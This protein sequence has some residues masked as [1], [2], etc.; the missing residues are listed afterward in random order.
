MNLKT[1]IISVLIG[2]SAY[3]FAQDSSGEFHFPEPETT[4][5]STPLSL[6]STQYYIHEFRSGGA[7]PIVYA[8]GESSGL[9][10]DTCDFCTASLEGTAYVTDSLGTITVINFAKSGDSSFVDCRACKKYASSKLKVESWGKT[11]WTKSEGFGDGVKNYR[12][13]PFRTI[14]V[15]KDVIPYGTVIYIPKA[16]G[17]IIELPDGEQVTHDG[18][19]FAG[20]TGGAIKKNHIDIF[21]GIY[22][23]NPFSDVIKSNEGKTFEAVIVTD[24]TIINALTEM[25]TK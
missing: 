15:D 22:S 7:I 12:L 24:A 19:F 17:K 3:S 4:A 14:A 9:F 21:T 23:G 16:K 5:L 1:K 8:N 11:L 25:H 6:W 20:D 13:I 10:A 2:L 18:Y